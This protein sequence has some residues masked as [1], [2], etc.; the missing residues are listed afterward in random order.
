M[1]RDEMRRRAVECRERAANSVDYEGRQAL[2]KAA[3]IWET[4]ANKADPTLRPAI[5][6]PNP[7]KS[8]G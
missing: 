2:L 1:E 4:L 7:D 8:G 3:A 6:N 5:Q